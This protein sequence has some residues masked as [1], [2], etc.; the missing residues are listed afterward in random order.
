MG[1]SADATKTERLLEDH[2][3]GANDEGA[4]DETESKRRKFHSPTRSV[5]PRSYKDLARS[6]R[7]AGI[8][9]YDPRILDS[10]EKAVRAARTRLPVLILGETGTGKELFASLVHERS[11]VRGNYIPVNCAALPETILDAELFGHSR[12]AFTG[13]LRDRA[14]LVEAADGGTLFLDEIGEMTLPV[15]G[16]LL[17]A[18]E[19]GEIRRLGETKP[20]YVQTRFVAATHRRL[21]EMIEQGSFRADLFYRLRGVVLL[22]PPLRDRI[23]DVDLLVD[24]FLAKLTR[25]SGKILTITEPAREA[26]N[27]YPWPGNVRELK[28]VMERVA[29][30]SDDGAKIGVDDLELGKLQSSVS[31]QEHLEEEER[32]RVVSVLES[33]HWNRSAAARALN[34]KR[35]TLL[36]KLKRLGITPPT[37]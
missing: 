8:V 15:Q 35:T 37:Q 20:R 9:S 16:R 5:L 14:G 24:F 2:R 34:M 13:A 21:E 7:E 1:A 26:L 10:F 4:D 11:S 32:R 30:L 27:Q 19:A 22:V 28:S 23:H 33:V 36:G 3:A 12:G 25:E 6:A 17:R 18:L 31:L 29:L